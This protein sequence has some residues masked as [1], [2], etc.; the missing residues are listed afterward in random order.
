MNLTQ[1]TI[2][3]AMDPWLIWAFRVT[4]IAWLGFAVGVLFIC[5]A[6]TVIGEL[7][8][9]GVYWLNRRHFASLREDMVSHNNL[10][11]KALAVKDKASYKAC[12]DLANDAFGRNFFS[13]IA[14][15]AASVWPAFFFLGWM[16]YRFGEVDFVLPL[17]GAVG[18]G[19]FFVP[20]YILTRIGFSKAKP[21]LPV[22]SAIRRKLL[23]NEAGE[24]MMTYSD[25]VRKPEDTATD[26]RS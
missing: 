8:M 26:G 14:L 4:D 19:F 16:D 13:H 2:Y 21:W 24:E 7:C 6:A 1:D 11:L 25:I 18:P 12:N 9:A 10:S 5:L 22:F 3:A 17:A 23:E 20:A 15:F